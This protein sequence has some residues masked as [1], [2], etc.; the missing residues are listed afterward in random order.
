V[1]PKYRQATVELDAGSLVLLYTDGLV[2]RRGHSIDEGLDALRRAVVD[3]PRDPDRLLDH[4]L[5]RVIGDEERGDDIAMLVVRALP[6]APQPLTLRLRA[7]L[8]SMDVVRDAMRVWLGGTMLDRREVED[9]V[10]AAWEACAN[11]IEHAVEPTS[12]LVFVTAEARDGE[13]RVVVSDTGE[14]APAT[15]RDDRGLGLPLIESLVTS[16]D[17]ARTGDGTRVTLVKTLA[18]AGPD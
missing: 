11:A 13:V 2:E 16:V 6:V 5:E 1:Q 4:V 7:D 3:G 10:L 8:S 9:V 15:A 14:W 12:D 18:A 17:V